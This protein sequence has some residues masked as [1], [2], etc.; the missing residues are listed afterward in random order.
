VTG[1]E[2][3]PVE[4]EDIRRIEARHTPPALRSQDTAESRKGPAD[5]REA[6]A[7]LRRVGEREPRLEASE[8][9]NFDRNDLCKLTLDGAFVRPLVRARREN[10]PGRERQ[11]R[12]GD[13]D[14]PGTPPKTHLRTSLSLERS[15]GPGERRKLGSTARRVSIIGAP[16]ESRKMNVKRSRAMAV[17]MTTEPLPDSSAPLR[18]L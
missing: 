9:R 4:H 6:S 2:L 17:A 10:E 8:G 5:T 3:L 16:S 14:T 13:Q 15:S 18:L 11:S 7:A 1:H 12:D